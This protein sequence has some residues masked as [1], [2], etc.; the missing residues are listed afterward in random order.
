MY[1]LFLTI[2]KK[3]PGLMSMILWFPQI[4]H[5]FPK[6]PHYHLEEATAAFRAKYPQL[7][8]VND[9]PILPDFVRRFHVFNTDMI[10]PDDAKFHFFGYGIKKDKK[11]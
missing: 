8:R 7:V 10:V 6:I 5:M 4:H 2:A 1:S 3:S 11:E 9:S